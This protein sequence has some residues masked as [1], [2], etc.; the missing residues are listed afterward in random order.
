MG[1]SAHALRFASRPAGGVWSEPRTIAQG[2]DWFV[3]WA[4]FPALAAFG[5]GAL[6]AHWLV[7]DRRRTSTP[8]RCASPSRA[9]TAAP[10]RR[11]IV[12]HRDGLP[13]NTG[14]SRCFP[15]RCATARARLARRPPHAG[16]SARARWR[17]STR[18]WTPRARSAR[19]SSSIRASATAAR[20]RPCAPPTRVVVAYRDRSEDEVR[21][22]ATVR[23]VERRLVRRRRSW[24]RT[25]GRST[26][27]R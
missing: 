9:T 11:G 6:A 20:P 10:G 14:S 16:T 12:P 22:I 23:Y 26:A 21:D 1:E 24:R 3:N 13:P 27:A 5:D 2:K 15:G 18:P 17:S 7:A 19:R 4:D 25:T 8:T